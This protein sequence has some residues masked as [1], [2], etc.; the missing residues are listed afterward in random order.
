MLKQKHSSSNTLSTQET[1]L[2]Q[3]ISRA[4]AAAA[5]SAHMCVYTAPAL[6]FFVCWIQ[7]PRMAFSTKVTN[8]WMTGVVL[9]NAYCTPWWRKVYS[10]GSLSFLIS[11]ISSY[12]KLLWE[13]CRRK[14]SSFTTERESDRWRC[15]HTQTHMHVLHRLKYSGSLSQQ[16]TH[17]VI[18][19]TLQWKNFRLGT[20]GFC[21]CGVH[22]LFSWVV[23]YI[24]S[25]FHKCL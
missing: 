18:V 15:S 16:S 11:I 3:H 10:T 13:T 5:A 8:K 9:D 1:L 25:C 2:E 21:S 4:A 12:A 20:H 19:K 17:T 24:Y 7:M 14:V 22:L 23:D 6:L